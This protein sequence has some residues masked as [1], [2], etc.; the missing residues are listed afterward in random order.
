LIRLCE[1]RKK[2]QVLNLKQFATGPSGQ[3]DHS[4]S[5]A[6]A[7]EIASEF[8]VGEKTVR[9]GKYHKRGE[10]AQKCPERPPGPPRR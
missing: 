6:T 4:G 2:N 8:G 1:R 7:R 10:T 3:F 9:R 5:T